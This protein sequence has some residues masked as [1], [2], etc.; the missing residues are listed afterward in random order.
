MLSMADGRTTAR[1]VSRRVLIAEAWVRFRVRFVVDEVALGQVFS[2]CISVIHYHYHS[3][4]V[5]YSLI[6]LHV[7]HTRKRNG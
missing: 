1:A 3:T 4:D 6:H 2:P 7:A 5:P